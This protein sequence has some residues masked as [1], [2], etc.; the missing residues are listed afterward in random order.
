MRA[1]TFA[2]ALVLAL[3]PAGLFAAEAANPGRPNIL[4]LM[5]EDLSPRIGAWG[6]PVARTPTIDALADRGVRY[7]NVFTTAGVCAPSRAAMITG[8]HQIAIG[9]QHMRTST[10]PLGM[11]LAVPPP[12]VKAFPELL[13][14]AGYYTFT[15][16][17]LDY[18]FSGIR[19]GTGPVTIWDAEGVEAGWQGRAPGQPFFGLINFLHTHESGVM[20]PTGTPHGDSHAATQRMRAGFG[21]VAP[22]VTDPGSVDLP[23]YYPDIEEVR[24]DLARHYDNIANM[25][26]AVARVLQRLAA[27][28]LADDTIVIW[29]TDHGDGLPRAKRELYD[30]GIRVPLI[31]RDPTGRADTAAVPGG[32]DERLVSF[33]DIAPTV[34]TIAGVATPPF[35]HGRSLLDRDPTT[36]RNY[37]FAS[38]DRIDEVPDRQ[39]AVRDARFKYIRSWHPDMPGGHPLDYRDNL[40]MVRAMRAGFET[41]TLTDVQALWFR[42]PGSEQLYDLGTD[43][44]EVSNL[45]DDPHFAAELARLRTVL[46]NWQLGIGD[47]S[48]EP[49]GV[50]R[51]RF[52]VDGTLAVTPP[53]RVSIDADRVVLTAAAGA[54]IEFR[55]ADGPWR[56]YTAPFDRRGTPITARAQRYGWHVSSTVHWPDPQTAAER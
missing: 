20:R 54:S 9:A 48:N 46:N 11:Y 33:V 42:G 21:L 22:A 5:A 13:R 26:R 55:T 10:G 15:D 37:V 18:Q 16:T 41:G 8:V 49:E 35:L 51:N 6:D 7:T 50:M 14:G 4:L 56:V 19:A 44:E 3:G 2:I 38:R 27:D 34:L 32:V 31:V 12:D 25:D 17:K 47:W 40:D 30:S 52:L 36:R 53:P 28:G 43:P 39:R 45:A 23:A 1:I 29:T 24:T